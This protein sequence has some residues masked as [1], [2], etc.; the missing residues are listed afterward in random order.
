MFCCCCVA[1]DNYWRS[2]GH[3]P[4][5]CE[6][7]VCPLICC[8]CHGYCDR[9]SR[10]L[11]GCSYPCTPHPLWTRANIRSIRGQTWQDAEIPWF[12]DAYATFCPLC[13]CCEV[14]QDTRELNDISEEGGVV[15]LHVRP[16]GEGGGAVAVVVAA[17]PQYETPAYA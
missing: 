8:P 14:C 10:C 16:P 3:H 13:A 15:S 1:G 17:P 5:C 9:L 4:K 11:T 12:C 6:M 7:F 2:I